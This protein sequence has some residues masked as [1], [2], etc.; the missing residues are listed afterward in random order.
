M[1]ALSEKLFRRVAVSDEPEYA[2]RARYV[3]ASRLIQEEEY[4]Q[5]MQLIK[6]MPAYDNLDKRQ[7]EIAICMK[8]GNL[9]EAGKLLEQKLNQ[10]IQEAFL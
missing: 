6:K 7:L 3:L 8:K 10:L 4:D 2:N 5:A 9:E 1:D